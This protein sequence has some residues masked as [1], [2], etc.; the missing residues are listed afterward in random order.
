MSSYRIENLKA[1]ID[2]RF[3]QTR[4]RR[5]RVG[6]HLLRRTARRRSTIQG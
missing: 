6:G 3:P 1:E 4:V 2:Y 5:Q